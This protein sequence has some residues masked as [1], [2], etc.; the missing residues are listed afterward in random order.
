VT[1]LASG[2][3]GKAAFVEADFGGPWPYAPKHRLFDPALGGGALLDLG[4]YPLQLATLVPGG[5]QR[6]AA[7]GVVGETGVDELVVAVAHHPGEGVSV[8]KASVRS[9]LSCTARIVGT[10]GYIE[11]PAFVRCPQS[12]SVTAPE[13]T[14]RIDTPF[15][16][17]LRFEIE[18][19][20]RCLAG[21]LRESDGVP[22][23]ETLTL[24]RTMDDI[25]AQLGVT[26]PG[27]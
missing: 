13:G 16:H 1:S 20:H 3:I 24:A 15:E 4:I 21:G 8:V 19:V 25:R 6:V 5:V 22:L 12:L 27:E 17:G 7:D 2:R 26:Y 10:G 14:E 9:Y 11:L 18:E 23:P